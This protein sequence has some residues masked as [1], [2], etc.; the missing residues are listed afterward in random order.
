MARIPSPQY[1]QPAALWMV[2]ERGMSNFDSPV[3]GKN[4]SKYA[5]FLS[6]M[7]L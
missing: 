1:I 3:R 2:D 6:R 4:L 7:G 5:V